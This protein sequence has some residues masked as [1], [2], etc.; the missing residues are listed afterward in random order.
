MSFNKLPSNTK[1]LLDEI[2]AAENPTQ[3]LSDRFDAAT[4]TE[5]D[6]TWVDRG[7]KWRGRG[8]WKH[9]RMIIL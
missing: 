7:W 3:Y 1:R 6:E 5:D 4:A 8:T 2:V 9:Q